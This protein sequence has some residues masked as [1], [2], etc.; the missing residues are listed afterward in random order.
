[1]GSYLGNTKS[2]RVGAFG[3]PYIRGVM[4]VSKY[5]ASS[6]GASFMP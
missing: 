1:M 2:T 5:S 6:S 4:I 3:E